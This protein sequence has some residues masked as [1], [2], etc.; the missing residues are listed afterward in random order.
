MFT[1]NIIGYSC[2]TTFSAPSNWVTCTVTFTV[3]IYKNFALKYWRM[4]LCH[5]QALIYLISL[6]L[7]VC[8]PKYWTRSA[9]AL[10]KDH[11]TGGSHLSQI[12]WEHENL[13]SL[14]VIWLIYIKYTMKRKK[15]WQKIQAKQES[16]LTAVQLKWDLPVFIPSMSPLCDF[17][18]HSS[19]QLPIAQMRPPPCGWS[20]H[21]MCWNLAF[22]LLPVRPH[23]GRKCCI[24][25]LAFA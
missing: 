5:I 13:S 21:K 7:W 18:S 10:H 16:R 12:F 11:T 2:W 25:A 20:L 1:L 3:V 19:L 17:A 24:V 22:Y 9:A 23:W 8:R 14:S 4:Q 15:N 6:T